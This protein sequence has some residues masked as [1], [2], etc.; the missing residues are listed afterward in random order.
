MTAS[1]TLDAALLRREGP[2]AVITL[3]RPEVRNAVNSEMAIAIGRHLEEVAYDREIRAVVITGAGD[4]SFCSCADLKSVANGGP[5]PMD[6]DHL[7]WGFASLIQH[8]IDK[9]LIAAVNGFA[10]GG[11]T[12]IALACDLVVASRTASFGLPE[13]KRGIV[14]GA[15][16]LVRLKQQIPIKVAMALTLTG[17][18]MSATEAERWGLI[19]AVVEPDEVV[20][21]A[22]RLGEAIAENAPL[23]IQWSRRVLLELVDG[24]RATEQTGWRINEEARRVIRSSADAREGARAFIEKRAPHWQ[25]A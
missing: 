16:G 1:D 20:P 15:G 9:P 25:G 17:Q 24:D 11:G 23:A 21:A 18:A 22:V 5:T 4:R 10:L 14:A 2:V 12:E 6:P 8:D 3:N 7:E 13:V 19:N